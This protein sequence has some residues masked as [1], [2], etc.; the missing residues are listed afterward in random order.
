MSCKF[1]LLLAVIGAVPVFTG[2]R[3]ASNSLETGLEFSNVHVDLGEVRPQLVEGSFSCTNTGK[4]SATILSLTPSCVCL[5][6]A[7]NFHSVTEGQSQEVKFK[8]DLSEQSIG[9]QNFKILVK[10]K[11]GAGAPEI[12]VLTIACFVYQHLKTVPDRVD[13]TLIGS[14]PINSSFK[15]V[16]FRKEKIEFG[17]PV[18]NPPIVNQFELVNPTS[19]DFGYHHVINFSIDGESIQDGKHTAI[20]TIPVI[21]DEE[22]SE[23]RVPMYVSK[24]SAVSVPQAVAVLQNKSEG[25]NCEFHI[26]IRDRSGKGIEIDS[27]AVVGH[28][29]QADFKIDESDGVVWVRC[30]LP[31]PIQK[32]PVDC[33]ISLRKPEKCLTITRLVSP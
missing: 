31:H 17:K 12:Q 8:L 9:P 1:F 5:D 21:H 22:Y 6:L 23:V 25:K 20:V 11:I 16:S 2:C 19:Y 33:R 26:P 24:M 13:V 10:T 30:A 4:D 14:E 28:E 7:N 29:T 3:P 27:I 18:S 32:F 15:I